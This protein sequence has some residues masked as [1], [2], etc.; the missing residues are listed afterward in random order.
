[1]RLADYDALIF[2][3]DGVLVDSETIHVAVE[4]EFLASLG[5]NYTH[6][7]YLS[8]FVGLSNADF[9]AQLRSDYASLTDDEFPPDFGERL[10]LLTWPRIEAELKSI[11]GVA[12]LIEAF[13]GKV[14]VGSSAPFDR[15]KRRL[16]L[17]GLTALFSPHIYSVDHVKNG[18]PA[19]DLFLHAAEQ[20]KVTP[21]R[22][23]VIEDSVHGVVAAR[24]AQMIPIGF[25]G[26]SHAD[27]GLKKRLLAN[28]AEIVVSSHSE[29]QA[30]L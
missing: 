1:M 10:Q 21:K 28:G 4:R 29:I 12:A 13:K 5:L 25:V 16:A 23:V 9:Y 27:A 3:S 18:K 2:D 30:L 8:Q 19:P 7:T 6:E 26:G 14:A 17:T 24:A 20:L 15:L 22:C 11:A